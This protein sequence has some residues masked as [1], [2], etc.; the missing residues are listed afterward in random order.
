[1]CPVYHTLR[2]GSIEIK[3][4]DSLEFPEGLLGFPQ[5]KHY[6]LLED[7]EQAPFLWL[8]SLENTDLSFVL[9]DP[10]VIKP[11]YQ[12]R[13]G[14]EEVQSIELDDPTEAR[15]FVICVVPQEI[16]NSSANLKGPI[17]INP[18]NRKARQIVLADE[19]LP[20]RFF[21]LQDPGGESQ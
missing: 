20:T 11:D 1:M 3:E 16:S 7:S 15:V 5:L 17:I 18:K 2:F 9:V 4:P 8:Q 14:K 19:N 12:I 6:A 13:V 21:F 10:S